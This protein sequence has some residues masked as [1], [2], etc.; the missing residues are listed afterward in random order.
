MEDRRN[1]KAAKLWQGISD[2]VILI[3][4]IMVYQNRAM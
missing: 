4:G 2:L 3:A 1:S